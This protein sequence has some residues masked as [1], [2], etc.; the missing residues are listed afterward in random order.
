MRHVIGDQNHFAGLQLKL[1]QI[2]KLKAIRGQNKVSWLVNSH[3]DKI[4]KPCSVSF[5]VVSCFSNGLFYYDFSK[6]I[7]GPI[8]SEHFY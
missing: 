1:F 5:G 3:C 8:K 7:F 6:F 2:W 4:T